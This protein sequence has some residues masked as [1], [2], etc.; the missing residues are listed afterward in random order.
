MVAEEPSS[1]PRSLLLS[2]I[3][4][5]YSIY[6]LL[7]KSKKHRRGACAIGTAGCPEPSSGIQGVKDL[8]N[9]D[10]IEVIYVNQK[11]QDDGCNINDVTWHYHLHWTTL[12]L[13]EDS[14]SY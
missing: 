12:S 7:C 1:A 6:M 4:V 14:M 13:I 9:F 10:S 8:I 11:I 5:C 3:F 2:A